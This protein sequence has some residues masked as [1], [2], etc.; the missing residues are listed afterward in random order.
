MYFLA[1]LSPP[2]SLCASCPWCSS[3]FRRI[4]GQGKRQKA[5]VSTDTGRT[6]P[7]LGAVAGY[8]P[9]SN[10]F[11][12]CLLPFDL[13]CTGPPRCRQPPGFGKIEHVEEARVRLAV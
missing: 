2:L 9:R 4:A 3:W 10:R 13:P 6:R 12:F 5:K 11:A 7:A 1:T 8:L